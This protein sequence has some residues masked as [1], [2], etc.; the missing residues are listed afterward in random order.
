[1]MEGK[2][3]SKAAQK[4]VDQETD[5]LLR[6]YGSTHKTQEFILL[7]EKEYQRIARRLVKYKLSAL[8]TLYNDSRDSLHLHRE[9]I[10]NAATNT[11]IDSEIGSFL[12]IQASIYKTAID[13]KRLENRSQPK[14]PF[15]N[16]L[17]DYGLFSASTPNKKTI[18]KEY[19]NSIIQ[20][21][22]GIKESIYKNKQAVFLESFDAKVFIGL[23]KL[24]FDNGKNQEIHVEFKQLIKSYGGTNSGGE[25]KAVRESLKNVY[26]TSIRMK[27]Y[28]DPTVSDIIQIT[29]EYHPID[30]IDWILRKGEKEGEETAATI[31]FHKILHNS[32]LAG[33][34]SFINM[35]LF[36]DLNS[37]ASKLLYMNLIR[38]VQSNTTI[39]EL[40]SLIRHFGIYSKNRADAINTIVQAFEELKDNDVIREFTPIYGKRNKME[41]V[42]FKLSEWFENQK[43]SE[44]LSI[45]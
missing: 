36:N 1:M 30:K 2:A 23:T 35:V 26:A 31:H 25:I 18:A 38:S 37:A 12:E 10:T 22:N 32:L 11:P 27:Q 44:I 43:Q 9:Q 4:L 14:H 34:Y 6:K 15:S 39:Y 5:T 40:D 21:R 17:L 3:M 20:E 33:N 28:F 13:I 16:S 45:G 19:G 29:E 24:W 8:T 41:Y 7:M 42:Q